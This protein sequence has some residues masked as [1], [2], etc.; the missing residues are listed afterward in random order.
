[1]YLAAVNG[2]LINPPYAPHVENFNYGFH[3]RISIY[4]T[5]GRPSRRRSLKGGD[6]L[7]LRWIVTGA[8]RNAFADFSL[9]CIVPP[10]PLPPV[11]SV[12]Q[13]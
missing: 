10:D 2:Q 7:T 11:P 1:M 5:L 3:G 12:P 13:V 8:M 6:V 4:D 9:D